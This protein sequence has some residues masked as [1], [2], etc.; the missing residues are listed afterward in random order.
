MVVTIEAN[1]PKMN[2]KNAIFLGGKDFL[3]VGIDDCLFQA[4]HI[5]GLSIPFPPHKKCQVLVPC[6]RFSR[7]E[8]HPLGCSEK[9]GGHGSKDCSGPLRLSGRRPFTTVLGHCNRDRRV[10]IQGT[11]RS[12]SDLLPKYHFTL[13]GFAYKTRHLHESGKQSGCYMYDLAPTISPR[14][15]QSAEVEQ[16]IPAGESMLTI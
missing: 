7:A 12:T 5:Q 15:L 11:C 6:R 14:P 10:Q 13:N 2:P 1:N 3:P 16:Q 8:T 4:A 9:A